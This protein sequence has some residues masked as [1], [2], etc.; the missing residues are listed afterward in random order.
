MKKTSRLVMAL[1]CATAIMQ[2]SCKSSVKTE[3]NDQTAQTP[4]VN[5]NSLINTDSVGNTSIPAINNSDAYGNIPDECLTYFNQQRGLYAANL[6]TFEQSLTYGGGLE[7][8][9][10]HVNTYMQ[11]P[12]W[13]GYQGDLGYDAPGVVAPIQ[14]GVGIG[15]GTSYPT[16]PVQPTYQIL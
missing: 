13:D 16:I 14:L 11:G 9:R 4:F 15:G 6:G 8:C 1:V 12:L 10:T 3:R 5:D 2:I 7:Y